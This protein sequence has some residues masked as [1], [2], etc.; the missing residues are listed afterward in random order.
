MNKK[1]LLIAVASIWCVQAKHYKATSERSFNRVLDNNELVAVLF[2]DGATMRDQERDFK[3][4]GRGERYVAYV[5]VD[6]SKNGLAGLA[7]AYD[8][9]KT[10]LILLIRNGKVYTERG[11][12]AS[13]KGEQGPAVIRKFVRTYFGDYLEDIREQKREERRASS[14][15][16]SFGVGVGYPAYYGP[17]YGYPYYGPYYGSPYYGG[18]GFSIGVGF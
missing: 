17:Y 10:P 5:S 15:S 7:S 13:L 6:V 18:S 11:Q 9:K 4:A 12:R 2:F 8:V 16:V 3:E 14:P 1:L